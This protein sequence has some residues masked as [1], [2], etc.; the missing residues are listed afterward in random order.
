MTWIIK[1]ISGNREEFE[2]EKIRRAI[3]K[4]YIDAELAIEEH[5]KEIEEIILDVIK[6]FNRKEHAIPSHEI[7]DLVVKELEKTRP[8]A[9]KTWK[10]F[11]EK[12]KK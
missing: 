4:A 9:A 3:K 11:E 1:R 5:E 12:Y 2:A 10:K 6:H 8:R 7:R